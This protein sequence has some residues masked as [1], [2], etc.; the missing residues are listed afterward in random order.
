MKWMYIVEKYL[1]ARECV[2]DKGIWRGQPAMMTKDK[3][4]EE[5]ADSLLKRT[6]GWEGER[7][8]KREGAARLEGGF[9][10]NNREN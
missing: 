6:G 5:L 4:T 7:K 8:Q 10:H 2:L 9:P 3:Q 1:C